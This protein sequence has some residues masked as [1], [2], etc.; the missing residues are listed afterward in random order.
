M[1][2][3]ANQAA[4]GVPAKAGKKGFLR[5]LLKDRR[6]GVTTLVSLMMPVMF[7][8]G[9]L[10]ADAAYISYRKLLLQQTVHA[11]ALAGAQTLSSYYTS[12]NNSTTA[13]VAAAQS[14]ARLN[15]PTATYGTVVPTA[16]VVLGNWNTTT[17]A[18]ISLASSGGSAPNA[19]Q[20]TGLN[21]SANS[22]PVKTLFAGIFGISSKDLTATATASYATGQ[23]FDTIIINDLSQSET[24]ST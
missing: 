3:V 11:A 23:N 20:V 2:I 4:N 15:M 5:R 16:N 6:A 9:P 12:G 21:T 22:N 24:C 19:V 1:P 10:F 8:T 7:G 18:F 17:G 14:F 13:V